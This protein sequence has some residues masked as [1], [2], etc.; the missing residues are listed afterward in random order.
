VCGSTVVNPITWRAID[1]TRW[2]VW[3]RCGACAWA[4][5]AIIS[6]AEA[7][8][9]EQDLAPALR[10]MAMTAAR[11]DRERMTWEADAIATALERDLIGP[12]D[13][14]PGRGRDADA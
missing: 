14:A 3:L 10:E 7:R 2:S 4:R 6:E 5:E 8:Q 1:R 12:A 11:L 13:F 9:L